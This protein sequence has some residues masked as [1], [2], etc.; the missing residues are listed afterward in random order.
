VFRVTV[1]YTVNQFDPSGPDIG[2]D[3]PVY[4]QTVQLNFRGKF[5]KLWRVNANADAEPFTT[6]GS[7]VDIGGTPMDTFGEIE[8]TTMIVKPQLQITMMRNVNIG[9]PTN[10]L[11]ELQY[12]V[13]TRNNNN[14][15][16]AGKGKLLY[17]GA[18]SRRVRDTLYEI[19]H[20]FEFDQAKHQE[21]APQPGVGPFG[22]QIQTS[23]GIF[24]NRAF[25][26]YWVQPYPVLRD[27][28][29]LGINLRG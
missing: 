13:G 22:K 17:V 27:F 18:T 5:E 29:L 28:R 8:R 1:N 10:Y 7:G 6:D 4:Q 12:F 24:Q 16:G 19:S 26:V 11:S 20:S 9:V 2:D 15:L 14:F 23:A 25:P 3:G 21:Q